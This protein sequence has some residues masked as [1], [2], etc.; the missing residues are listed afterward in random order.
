MPSR[1]LRSRASLLLTVLLIA[2]PAGVAHATYTGVRDA[3]TFGTVAAGGGWIAVPQ[4]EESSDPG[5]IDGTPY[6]NASSSMEIARV[7]GPRSIS[8][9]AVTA[10]YSTTMGPMLVAGAPKTIAVAWADTAGAGQIDTATLNGH[11][12]LPNPFTQTG[13]PSGESPRLAS[14]PDGAYAVSWRD[15]AGGHAVAAAAGS[16]QPTALLGSDVPLD[17]AD[18]VVLSGGQS[19]WLLKGAASGLTAA[20]AVFGQD[21]TPQ[22][23][24][25]SGASHATTL[26]DDAGGLWTLA[27]S[28][29]GWSVAH[30]D[31]GGQLNSTPLPPGATHPLI[32]LA[33]TTA[34]IAYRAP[35]H[36]ITY[37]ERLHASATPHT[38]IIRTALTPHASGCPTPTNIAIDPTSATAYVLMHSNHATTLTTETPT[39]KTSHWHGSLKSHIDAIV[40]A[41]SNR[42]V[43]ESN[44]P[45]RDLGEQCGGANSSSTQSYF[46]RIFHQARLERSGQLD[47]SVLNC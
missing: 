31:R 12:K 39:H 40:P 32:A 9:K 29:E 45:Q 16:Q 25:L 23:V 5:E 6:S 20:P 11:G 18:R 35:T 43:L 47:A 44:G 10:K 21:T 8:F 42:V 30:I 46:I 2:A 26:G 41:G 38:P 13:A 36:C 7:S 34:V 33:G 24:T 15:A 3:T 4:R 27:H 19:F 28:E 37:I 22:T 17:P 1:F 14:G